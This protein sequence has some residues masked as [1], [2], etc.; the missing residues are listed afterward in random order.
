MPVR[1]ETWSHSLGEC[2][3]FDGHTIGLRVRPKGDDFLVL[4]IQLRS[5]ASCPFIEKAG[6]GWNQLW[7]ESFENLLPTPCAVEARLLDRLD[8]CFP[9]WESML[10]TAI[11]NGS[12]EMLGEVYVLEE[13][14]GDRSAA[15]ECEQE[16]SETVQACFRELFHGVVGEPLLLERGMSFAQADRLGDPSVALPGLQRATYLDFCRRNQRLALLPDHFQL[17][18]RRTIFRRGLVSDHH[19]NIREVFR[20]YPRTPGLFYFSR[21]GL[22]GDRNQALVIAN[23]LDGLH[24]PF[25]PEHDPLHSSSFSA[26]CLLELDQGVWRLQSLAQWSQFLQF[27]G[28]P[29]ERI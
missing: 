11:T 13:D 1:C 26:L 21:T 15:A 12:G 3:L 5:V 19:S 18:G 29:D 14:P 6:L 25:R 24:S 4:E 17:G 20:E 10:R 9:L 16:E 23:R 27:G 8:A 28:K 7:A 22:N 2:T